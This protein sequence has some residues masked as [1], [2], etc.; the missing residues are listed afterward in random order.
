MVSL[1]EGDIHVAIWTDVTSEGIARLGKDV[2]SQYMR[3]GQPL[4]Y[5]GVVP[6][7]APT[8]DSAT[9]RFIAERMREFQPCFGFSGMVFQGRGMKAN[10]K[11][12]VFAGVLML[13]MKGKWHVVSEANE[14]IDRCNGDLHLVKKL[15]TAKKL[16]AEKGYRI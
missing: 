2:H 12:T 10:I 16:A 3:C 4:V 13:A 7:D 5:I 11:R 9:R 15:L 6:E 8:P 1:E 14:L